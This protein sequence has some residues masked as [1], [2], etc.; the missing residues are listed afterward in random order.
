MGFLL[1]FETV[2]LVVSEL[3]FPTSTN[4][5]LLFYIEESQNPF[6]SMKLFF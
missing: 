4:L 2:E 1:S 5:Y 3:D 6:Y